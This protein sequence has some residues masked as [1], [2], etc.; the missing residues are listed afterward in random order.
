V[1]KDE[2]LK[3]NFNNLKK[4]KHELNIE[5]E[6]WFI[7]FYKLVEIVTK[8][9]LIQNFSFSKKIKKNIKK[10]NILAEFYEN[11]NQCMYMC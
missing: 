11:K 8:K 10:Y 9:I 7:S 1:N 3:I 2:N 5:R 6:K 4:S